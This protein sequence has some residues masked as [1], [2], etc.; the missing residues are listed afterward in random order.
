[1]FCSKCGTQN[2]E[3]AQFCKSCGQSLKP[4][5]SSASAPASSPV[6]APE[7]TPIPNPP[8]NSPAPLPTS[9]SPVSVPQ[10]QIVE[11]KWWEKWWGI[12]LLIAFTGVLGSIA[13]YFIWR[14]KLPAPVKWGATIIFVVI[15]WMITISILPD[16]QPYSLL[17]F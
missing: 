13:I 10:V 5:L 16:G 17:K 6:S 14:S 4:G 3:E 9:P 15:S 2:P 7:I 1:M 12:V 8:V 11:K